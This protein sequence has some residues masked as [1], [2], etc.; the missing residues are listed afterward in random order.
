MVPALDL[1]ICQPTLEVSQIPDKE[2][3][4][5]TSITCS[6]VYDEHQILIYYKLETISYFHARSQR[7]KKIQ[8]L[9]CFTTHHAGC[10]V[11]K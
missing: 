4:Q 1:P 2:Q 5:F 7:N 8:H 9:G 10:E 3:L 6:S 11:A